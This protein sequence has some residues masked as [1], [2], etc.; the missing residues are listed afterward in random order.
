MAF[1]NNMWVFVGQ[2]GGSTTIRYSLDGINRLEAPGETSKILFGVTYAN[3][4]WVAVGNTDDNNSINNTS[5]IHYSINGS[6]WSNASSP[7]STGFGTNGR[8]VAFGNGQWIAVGIGASNTQ[9]S[10]DGINWTVATNNIFSSSTG[11][12]YGIVNSSGFYIQNTSGLQL[13]SG[14]IT[15]SNWS[16]GVINDT[17]TFN[18][19]YNSLSL[20]LTSSIIN[21]IV[22]TQKGSS[23]TPSNGASTITFS[24]AFP[25]IPNVT[26]TVTGNTLGLMLVTSATSTNFSVSTFTIAGDATPLKFNWLA[27]I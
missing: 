6:N 3:G 2:S 23:Q 11:G 19:P 15:L 22:N 20:S 16:I 8:S 7:S 25:S 4:L 18:N 14:Q 27:T 1:G 9:Y 17:L 10:V 12:G 26:T 5:G 21:S 24:T 13:T